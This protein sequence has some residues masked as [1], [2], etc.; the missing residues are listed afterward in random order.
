MNKPSA[1]TI[2]LC[3][4]CLNA[5]ASVIPISPTNG[6]MVELLPTPQ[7]KIMEFSTY[8]ERLA[9]L[10]DDKA[11]PHDDRYYGKNRSSKWRTSRPLTLKWRT[12]DGEGSPWKILLGKRPDLA[13]ATEIWLNPNEVQ[14]METT[15]NS[16][17]SE[18]VEGKVR[19]YTY[20]V[21]RPNLEIGRTY[22]WKVWSNVKCTTY[23]HGSTIDKACPCGKGRVAVAS[24]TASFT[25]EDQPPRWIML[26]GR[27]GN[28]RDLGGWKTTDGHR[29]KQGLIFRGQGLND[30]SVNG[31]RPGHNRLMVEDVNYMKD[32]LGIKTD[33]DL[34]TDREVSN[35]DKSPLGADVK[36][37]Q[38]GSPSY[39]GLFTKGGFNDELCT[40]S[41]KTM[42]ENFRVFCDKT[43]YP[44]YFHCIGGAD[45]TGSL[46]Y[47]ILGVLGVSKHDIEVEWEATFYPLLP[48]LDARYSGKGYWRRE[49]HFDE[50]FAKY[51]DADTPWSKRIEL[52]LIDCGVT[53]DEINRFR[54][55]MLE[56]QQ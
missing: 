49:Q 35:M 20:T 46:A 1:L 45:R 23:S 34:R 42:A 41:M 28:I 16:S 44:I 18:K 38:H 24:E 15:E 3:S 8:E 43:N 39:A 22:Y 30:N 17:T 50:G 54:S 55:I 33:L 56:Q 4:L 21:P 32:V 40:T 27:V 29:V 31:D 25:T 2:A 52:Y 12:T 19:T 9:I 26:E 37:I 51:G 11:K 53:Q 36:F 10:R 48:E 7:K 13:D 5:S 47:I 14:K 6:Q